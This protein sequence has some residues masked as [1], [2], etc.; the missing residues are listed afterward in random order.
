[1]YIFSFFINNLALFNKKLF[2]F[3]RIIIHSGLGYNTW[4][5]YNPNAKVEGYYK[6]SIELKT[7]LNKINKDIYYRINEDKVYLNKEKNYIS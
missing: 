5:A 2:A 3:D 7:K 4:K 1:M 6:P